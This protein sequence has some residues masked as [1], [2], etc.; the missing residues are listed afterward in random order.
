MRV[1]QATGDEAAVA[2]QHRTAT[3]AEEHAARLTEHINI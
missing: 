1:R 2:V 3:A